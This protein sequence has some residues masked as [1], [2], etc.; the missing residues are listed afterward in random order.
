MRSCQP[1]T[2]TP[3]AD[4]SSNLSENRVSMP[5]NGHV[6]NERDTEAEGEK[7]PRKS[8]FVK[9]RR[10]G[11]KIKKG[12]T[13]Q[14]LDN[15]LAEDACE[16]I[17]GHHCTRT[18]KT[19]SHPQEGVANG[20]LQGRKDSRFTNG[21]VV[22][23]ELIGGISS[24][25]SEGE[26]SAQGQDQCH[27]KPA[28][29]SGKKSIP[30]CSPP[31]RPPMRICRTCGGR[32]NPVAAVL[33]TATRGTNSP[34]S[35]CTKG[36]R[37]SPA[38][39]LHPGKDKG[40]SLSLP[41]TQTER[42]INH[43]TMQTDRR[44]AVVRPPPNV[45][46]TNDQ[47]SSSAQEGEMVKFTRHQSARRHTGTTL[48]HTN[49]SCP[50]TH[51]VVLSGSQ[52]TD[53]RTHSD[54]CPFSFSQ[55]PKALGPSMLTLSTHTHTNINASMNP[56]TSH[57]NIQS[58]LAGI[59][60]TYTQ[61]KTNLATIQHT[62]THSASNLAD[63]EPTYTHS[64]PSLT[65]IEP[66][67]TH[68][69]PDLAS[70]H[71][72]HTYSK[73]N[74]TCSESTYTHPKPN[75][76]S[77]E[78]TYIHSKSNLAGIEPTYTHSK[79]NLA[80][81]QPTYTHIKP[82]R[83]TIKPTNSLSKRNTDSVEPTCTHSKPNLFCTEPSN[84]HSKALTFMQL[85]INA[86]TN[87]LHSDLAQP[88]IHPKTACKSSSTSEPDEHSTPKTRSQTHSRVLPTGPFHTAQSRHTSTGPQ[89]SPT[90]AKDQGF[91]CS[92]LN[93][94]VKLLSTSHLNS[95]VKL[96]S[97]LEAR[98]NSHWKPS[99]SSHAKPNA[100]HQS[101]SQIHFNMDPK[102]NATSNSN[103]PQ[104]RSSSLHTQT[105]STVCGMFLHINTHKDTQ[106]SL[107][108]KLPGLPAHTN[109]PA[110][111]H[112]TLPHAD[113]PTE[114]H[115]TLPHADPP[116][117]PHHTL[118]HADPP[119]EPHHILPRADPP[120]EPHH[121]LPHA[122]LPTE[123]HHTLPHADP[124]T[125]PH[126]TL[127]HSDP[128]TEP[129]LTL[130]HIDIPMEP[131]SSFKHTD[132]P[133]EPHRTLPYAKMHL[134]PDGLLKSQNGSQ[135]NNP[136]ISSTPVHPSIYPCTVFLPDP[137]P[138][139]TENLSTHNDTFH[140]PLSVVEV[141]PFSP[142]PPKASLNHPA[143]TLDPP[144]HEQAPP[145]QPEASAN[146]ASIAEVLTNRLCGLSALSAGSANMSAAMETA[147]LEPATHATAE[148]RGTELFSERKPHMTSPSWTGRAAPQ[149]ATP[150]PLASPLAPG[151]RNTASASHAHIPCR[152]P[153]PSSSPPLR[154][155]FQLLMEVAG[156]RNP[157]ADW[158][159]DTHL[160][161]SHVTPSGPDMVAE[162]TGNPGSPTE[163]YRELV[164][165]SQDSLVLASSKPIP[166]G[167][168]AVL[169][170]HPPS[171]VLL[172]PMSPVWSKDQDPYKRIER[173][174]ASL[175]SNQERITTLLNIIQDLEMSHALSNG[176]RCFRTGQDLNDC[177]TCQE[178]ACIIYSVEYDFRQQER[179]FSEVLQPLDS[180]VREAQ[181][182]GNMDSLAFFIS[183][184][185]DRTS[186]QLDVRTEPKV[187]GRGK[188]KKLYRKLL[189]WLP[190][191]IHRK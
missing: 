20:K 143:D 1:R 149:W 176:R 69:K 53:M 3:Q 85:H 38:A 15:E 34:T 155:A 16:A 183:L 136:H 95:D 119:T 105:P 7:G 108:P 72:T 116:T 182:D 84:T 79:P 86:D 101:Q 76:A 104:P 82:N 5:A 43:R 94:G 30:P 66:T 124:P 153:I 172:A 163:Q 19:H 145:L 142:E 120:T 18:I 59:Q 186:P 148:G 181:E 73:P 121:T 125:E 88:H 191:R 23:S 122:D 107:H 130:P 33:Y 6:P 98:H 133:T 77:I 46:A 70:I 17:K 83:A 157:S 2:E 51:T 114:P 29:Q 132:M 62:Y 14:G 160:F 110:E 75:P 109:M 118:P 188:S 36:L 147:A 50:Y 165:V 177:S 154:P 144:A 158:R 102:P 97:G 137:H 37:S 106:M 99:F 180:P 68:L 22:D 64:K 12:V 28:V 111:P 161:P 48:P 103:H 45:N 150:Q 56:K 80:C 166:N 140:A 4:V 71:P 32:K 89:H 170:Y 78:P 169:H 138:G 185:R 8:V 175:Q 81:I 54:I 24:D 159:P 31:R 39:S 57:N 52:E 164:T 100:K 184:H 171:G 35:A 146:F 65:S 44:P 113:P 127:P 9:G 10:L 162:Q 112:H 151:A 26:E 134:E 87:S 47:P 168:C 96:S 190:R 129:H 91:T 156:N 61:P 126:H 25:V 123:P 92:H 41:C 42:C 13:F 178:T 67:Y 74:L 128:P 40:A 135:S 21:S 27:P 49:T 93:L 141:C 63:V 55:T 167:H 179:R 152:P 115:H 90:S 58:N 139:T 173:V 11:R 187:K 131:H 117:E 189:G 60:P 174:E